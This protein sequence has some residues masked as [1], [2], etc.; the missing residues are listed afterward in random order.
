ML[1]FVLSTAAIALLAGAV[2]GQHIVSGVVRDADTREAL[3][4]ATVRLNGDRVEVTDAF[5]R[6]L[7][8][9][10]LPASILV[11]SGHDGPSFLVYDN[12]DAILNW[13]RSV[14]YAVAIGHLERFVLRR[15]AGGDRRVERGTELRVGCRRA[16]RASWSSK[17]F[18]TGA[19]DPQPGHRQRFC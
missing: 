13:N 3:V 14:L 9:I 7:P 15:C 6:A 16:G 8:A 10:D 18:T 17:P 19:C 11:P 1:K 2:F 5:G 12:F 4:N